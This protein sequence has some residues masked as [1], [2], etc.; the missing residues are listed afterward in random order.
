M[1]L[2]G[3]YGILAFFFLNILDA[4]QLPKKAL[5]KGLHAFT[6]TSIEYC[7]FAFL[8]RNNID[9]KKIKRFILILSV[10]FIFFQAV[11]FVTI[12]LGKLDTIPVGIETILLFVFIFLFFYENLKSPKTVYIYN[13]HCFWIAVGILIYL[14]SAFFIFIL[15][16]HIP[17]KELRK[18]WDL[19]YV[20][21]IL[22][23]IFFVV[24]IF[25]YSSK[26]KNNE[27]VSKSSVPYLDMN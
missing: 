26:M 20:A 27:V 23:N 17:L 22:K 1:L 16:N 2:L 6:Y 25:L 8:I 15:A 24:S 7:S 18:Y 11:F 4:D 9:S 3:I 14:G 19:T 21:E 13:N 10:L 12:P 5:I